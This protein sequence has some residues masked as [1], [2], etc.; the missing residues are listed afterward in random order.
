MTQQEYDNLT[1][2]EKTQ[3]LL[4]NNQSNEDWAADLE[5]CSKLSPRQLLRELGESL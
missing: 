4:G 2:E 3:H 1:Q 5:R